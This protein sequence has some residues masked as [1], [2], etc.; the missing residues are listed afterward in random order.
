MGHFYQQNGDTCYTV[1][2]ANGKT[3]DT[4]IADA[5]KRNLVPSVTTV[6]SIINK[7]MVNM[8][9]H[10]ELLKTSLLHPKK[11]D[12]DESAWIKRVCAISR[13]TSGKAARRGTEIHDKLEDYFVNGHV[14][15]EDANIIMPVKDFLKTEFNGQAWVAEASFADKLG[16]G[17]KVDLHSRDGSG[18]I[19]DFKTKAKDD[20]DAKLLYFDYCI[21]LAAYRSGLDMKA[22]TCYNL[23]ISTTSPGVLYLHKW[24]E[25]SLRKGLRMFK[26]MLCYW[27]LD[28]AYDPSFRS[29]D[30]E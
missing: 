19:I 5:R 14:D 10:G 27:G 26:L 9:L 20:L 24:D 13:E 18:I 28:N 25:E 30:D 11:S 2:G 1:V 29:G 23:I 17:G 8:W 12:E 3:R 6:T 21:Q 7:P 4:N 15:S 22:A 16:F